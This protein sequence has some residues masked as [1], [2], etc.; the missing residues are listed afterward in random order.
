VLHPPPMENQC[1]LAE[2]RCAHVVQCQFR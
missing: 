1:V 2:R